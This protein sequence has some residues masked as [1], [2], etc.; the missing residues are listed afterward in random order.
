M[1]RHLIILSISLMIGTVNLNA[2]TPYPENAREKVHQFD[3]WYGEWDVYRYDT[4][5]LVAY[6]RVSA[7]SGQY[8]YTATLGRR[9]WRLLLQ[10]KYQ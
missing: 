9:Q 4:D 3:F 10:Y 2:Q 5:S 6:S 8:R 7:C 1:Y